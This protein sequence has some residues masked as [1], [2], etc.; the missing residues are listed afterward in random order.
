MAI[1][2]I[3]SCP[4]FG[5]FAELIHIPLYSTTAIML[6]SKV[7]YRS[8]AVLSP[9][10]QL[11]SERLDMF[12]FS[13]HIEQLLLEYIYQTIY[14]TIYKQNVFALFHLKQS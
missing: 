12:S 6:W 14:Q 1:Q 10:N 9:F 7:L 2:K 3:R 8:P 4:E 11:N 5:T 13:I